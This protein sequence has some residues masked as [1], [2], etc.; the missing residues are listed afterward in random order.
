MTLAL[1]LNGV[2]IMSTRVVIPLYGLWTA[3]VALTS[4]QP[5]PST[6]GGCSLALGNL[7]LVGT[8]FRAA[9]FAGCRTSR[10]VGGYG[11][12]RNPVSPRSYRNPAGVS[13]TMILQDLAAE[14]GEQI[15]V[16]QESTIGNLFTRGTPGRQPVA[17]DVLR[18][19]AGPSWWVDGSGKTQV[20]PRPSSAISSTFLVES[21]H[22]AQGSFE[23]ST[24]DPASWLPGNTFSNDTLASAQ[25][26]S[27]TTI[28][29]ENSGKVR[30]RV[31]TQGET[32]GT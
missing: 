7:S 19:I 30:L 27:M 13:L 12:W 3:D 15:A 9:N 6:P 5:E 10:I 26:I 31:L 29:A 14:V 28:L 25:T 4:A 2:Q 17:S 8:A 1:S 32:V 22:G 20:G 16:A 24:E 21:W 23:V 18:Q 11:G